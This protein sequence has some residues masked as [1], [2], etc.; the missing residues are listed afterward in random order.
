MA[1]DERGLHECRKALLRTKLQR[2]YTTASN[3][4]NRTIP[5]QSPSLDGASQGVRM[6][7]RLGRNDP[8]W[9]GSG[10]KF[11][12][13]H[14]NR[15]AAP[16]RTIQEVIET[17]QMAYAQKLCLHPDASTCKR[18]IIK[19]HSVQ[20]NGGLSAI[21][22]RGKVYGIRENNVGDLSKTNGL[23]APKLVG[24]GN[25]STF[26]GMCGFH[27]DETFRSHR[28]EAVCRLS[29]TRLPAR[30]PPF[31]Q[32]SL[33]QAGG[34]QPVPAPAGGGCRPAV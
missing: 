4:S 30:L 16:P 25:A 28:E 1:A 22:V 24:A 5:V 14:L 34:G 9:C 31:L 8:C 17:G 21:A 27:D 7:L 20:R 19:A 10:K 13:C 29:R 11:K 12:K 2:R 3:R 23:L 15:E 18:G 33:H 32:G 26:T 6:E